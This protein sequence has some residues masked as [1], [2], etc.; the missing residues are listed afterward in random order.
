MVSRS[1][2]RDVDVNENSHRSSRKGY[3]RLP[4]DVPDVLKS[5]SVLERDVRARQTSKTFAKLLA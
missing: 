4:L 1:N 2:K 5:V 3:P